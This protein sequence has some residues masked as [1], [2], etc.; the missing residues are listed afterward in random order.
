MIVIYRK[1][2]S[3]WS[4]F[5]HNVLIPFNEE[6]HT[7][8]FKMNGDLKHFE[9]FE[10]QIVEN[11]HQNNLCRTQVKVQFNEDIKDM[12]LKPNGN[13]LVIFYGAHKEELVKILSN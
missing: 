11:L 10:G 6:N 4:I 12:F 5:E 13:H 3:C 7:Q 8:I 2:C 9:V 1:G